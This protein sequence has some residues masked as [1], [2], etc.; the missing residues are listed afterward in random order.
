L[1]LFAIFVQDYNTDPVRLL[2][3]IFPK[4]AQDMENIPP[5]NAFSKKMSCTALPRANG[6]LHVAVPLLVSRHSAWGKHTA[7]VPTSQQ[8]NIDEH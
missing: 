8:H 4:I 3:P 7:V 5:A 6:W 1:V 2:R